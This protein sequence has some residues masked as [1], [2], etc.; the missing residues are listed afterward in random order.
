M[1][2]KNVSLKNYQNHQ[3][4]VAKINGKAMIFCTLYVVLQ[5]Y[6]CLGEQLHFLAYFLGT[7]CH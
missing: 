2:I 6:V 5:Y 4:V 3:K 1:Q 7:Y